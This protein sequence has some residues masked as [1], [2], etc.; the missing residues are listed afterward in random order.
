MVRCMRL[1]V[2]FTMLSRIS[3]A[4]DSGKAT[5]QWDFEGETA[6]QAPAVDRSVKLASEVVAVDNAH[7]ASCAQAAVLSAACST[8]GGALCSTDS[9]IVAV[10]S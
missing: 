10:V 3:L 2:V 9:S 1:I 8:R 7:H 4:Q 5:R 6:G